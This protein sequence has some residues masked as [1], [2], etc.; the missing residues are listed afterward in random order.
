MQPNQREARQIVAESHPHPP[1]LVVVTTLALL[2]FLAL[3]NVVLLVTRHAGGFQLFFMQHALVASI[4]SHFFMLVAE[5]EMGLI[6]V[7]T[8]FAPAFRAVATLALGSIMPLV[9]VVLLVASNAGAFQL[10]GV[11]VVFM[12]AFALDPVVLARQAELGIPVM[13][14]FLFFPFAGIMALVTFLPKFAAVH[15]VDL[16]A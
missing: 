9:F 15:I 6:V 12:A 11:R 5:L 2:A 4:T 3:V 1:A 10:M 14:E 13:I 7:E 8:G 16:M